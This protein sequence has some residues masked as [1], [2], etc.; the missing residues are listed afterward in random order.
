MAAPESKDV[1][2]SLGA[3]IGVVILGILAVYIPLAA[4]ERFHWNAIP[5]LVVYGFGGLLVLSL[6]GLVRGWRFP[7]ARTPVEP[8][9]PTTWE[10]RSADTADVFDFLLRNTSPR[11]AYNVGIGDGNFERALGTI[12]PNSDGLFRIQH[13]PSYGGAVTVTWNQT[14]KPSDPTLSWT[15]SIPAP[16]GK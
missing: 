10:I 5:M 11:A 12:E 13:N 6:V 16:A 2:I 3:A 8:V 15:G 14:A 9:E 1:W 4:P 7:Y